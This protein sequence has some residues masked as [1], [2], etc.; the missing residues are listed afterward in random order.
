MTK[1]LQR[2]TD[3]GPDKPETTKTK[4]KST[5]QPSKPQHE[6]GHKNLATD[7]TAASKKQSETKRKPRAALKTTRTQADKQL[8]PWQPPEPS[9]ENT[10]RLPQEKT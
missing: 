9:S 6:E 2:R 7:K 4:H 1:G 5:P 8:N 10:T 3:H